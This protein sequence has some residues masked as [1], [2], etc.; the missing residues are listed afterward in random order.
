MTLSA[1]AKVTTSLR[2]AKFGV[3]YSKKSDE[4]FNRVT[5]PDT[6]DAVYD[7]SPSQ[8]V[9]LEIQAKGGKKPSQIVVGFVDENGRNVLQMV[10]K[11]RQEKF[12]LTV[13]LNKNS[14]SAL[15]EGKYT[16]D[17]IIGDALFREAMIWKG[18]VAL[19]CIEE[20]DEAEKDYEPVNDEIPKWE[21]EP[22]IHHTFASA[23]PTP[24]VIFP[25]L[26]CGV[27]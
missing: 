27:V 7:A 6:L 3:Q 26:F 22:E 5:Y 25:M 11:T 8:K 21:L 4:G 15:K 17:L 13:D 2:T 23:E 19:E 16:V 9:K 1:S 20:E 14:F 24:P 10:P 18:I 12:M